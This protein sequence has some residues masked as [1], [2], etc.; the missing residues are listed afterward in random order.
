MKTERL[1]E[2]LCLPACFQMLRDSLVLFGMVLTLDGSLDALRMFKKTDRLQ[3]VLCSKTATKQMLLRGQITLST[4][5]GRI[6]F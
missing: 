2:L 4:P 6:V 3:N 5:Y 1:S